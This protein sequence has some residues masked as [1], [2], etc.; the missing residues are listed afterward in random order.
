MCDC[1]SLSA[2]RQ[3]NAAPDDSLP[4][5]DQCPGTLGSARPG[6]LSLVGGA[7]RHITAGDTDACQ[8]IARWRISEASRRLSIN[9]SG[10]KQARNCRRRRKLQR[11]AAGGRSATSS[12]PPRKPSSRW[13]LVWP[14]RDALRCSAQQKM[15]DWVASDEHR[16]LEMWC[17]SAVTR[18]QHEVTHDV[19]ASRSRDRIGSNFKR[20]SRIHR[21]ERS[22]VECRRPG[23][24]SR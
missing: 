20:E 11:H 2:A 19:A 17:R 24:F 14:G 18:A 23:S 22:R 3:R 7:R 6:E 4:E 16:C 10:V 5:G 12:T 8:S 15:A 1:R 21:R 9:T 13:W